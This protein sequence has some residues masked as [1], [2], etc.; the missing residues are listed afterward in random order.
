M[1]VYQLVLRPGEYDGE[2][3]DHDE[4]F[5]SLA[6]AKRRRAQLKREGLLQH[7]DG[8]I[9]RCVLV[10]EPKKRLALALLN[11]EAC[12]RSVRRVVEPWLDPTVQ[13][14]MRDW[15]GKS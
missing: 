2:G 1:K 12:F 8:A 15:S 11:Q 7:G 13:R 9:N 6:L 10:D 3:E 5:S 14:A 4:W